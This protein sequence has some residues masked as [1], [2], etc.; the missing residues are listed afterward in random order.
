MKIPFLD[1]GSTYLDLQGDLDA[2]YQR[3][4]NSGWYILGKEVRTFESEFANYCQ[5][6]HCIGVGNGLDAYV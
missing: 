5:A 1:L 2:A 6:K 4:M 3:V